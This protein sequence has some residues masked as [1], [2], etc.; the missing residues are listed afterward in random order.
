MTSS[1]RWLPAFLLVALAAGACGSGPGPTADPSGAP[2]ATGPSTTPRPTERPFAPVAWP[3]QGSACDITGYA[4]RLGRVEAVGPQ[5]VRFTLCSADGAFPARL[6]HPSLGVIDAVAVDAVAANPGAARGVAG[7]G[8]FRVEAWADDGNLRLARI[9]EPAAPGG[10]GPTAPA[11]TPGSPGA[12]ASGSGAPVSS[13]PPVI[14][15]R[16]ATSPAE[17]SAALR[18]ATVDGIDAPAPSDAAD[19][20]TLPELVVLPRPGLE[21]AYLGFGTGKSLSQAAVRR[22]FAQALDQT[23]IARDAFPPG[24]A[25][26]THTT[27]CEVPAGCAGIPWY[28]FNGPAASAALDAAGFDRKVPLVLHVPDAP[29]PGLP[30]PAATAAAVRDQLAASVDV[31][32]EIDVMSA[33]ELT[34]GV[35]DGTVGG[36]YLGGVASTLADPSGFLEP[37]FGEKATGTAAER[38]KGVREAL[39]EAA[40]GTTATM[41]AAAFAAAN[42]AVRSTAAIVPLAHAGS[43]VAYRADVAAVAV[44]PLGVDPVGTF[45][46]GDRRQLV[47]MGEGEPAGAWCAVDASPGALRLC[48]LV[49]PGMYAFD[50]ATLTPRP[51]LAS[52]CTPAPG[53]RTWTCRLREDLAFSDGAR[54][55][56]GDVVASIRAQADAGS[57]LRAAFPATAF[58]AWDELFGGPVPATPAPA[59]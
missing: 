9:G 2:G 3:A 16:W 31:T 7:A 18:A 50:G 27:P 46:P 22:A 43:T 32:V 17:R 23:A 4:G 6:A 5:T 56:A 12:S 15:L 21:T 44:S 25:P 19:M 34:A 49:T 40:Q 38:A 11:A 10:A 42:D 48:A 30:N 36:L 52:R 57:A 28:E 53:A 47:V 37:L 8:G 24:S 39:A 51:A 14:V 41:R 20:A 1:R 45:V 35:A 55:D 59:P 58:A 26:A 29:L 13:P 54:V 33:S